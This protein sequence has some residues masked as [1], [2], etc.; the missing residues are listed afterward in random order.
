MCDIG[1]IIMQNTALPTFQMLVSLINKAVNH[2]LLDA[3]QELISTYGDSLTDEVILQCVH[4]LVIKVDKDTETNQPPVASNKCWNIIRAIGS[5]DKFIPKLIE[6]IEAE[7]FKLQKYLKEPE[8]IDFE[9]DFLLLCTCFISKSK[10]VTPSQLNLFE[11]FWKI[12]EK[13]GYTFGHMFETLSY[14]IVYG[15]NILKSAPKAIDY[16][17]QICIK[18]ITLPD[19]PKAG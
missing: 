19:T 4:E 13:Y 6:P 9:E 12:F 16:L 3:I 18:S 17:I 14:F 15:A 10:T 11:S 5:K 8:K 2:K 7:I 1:E